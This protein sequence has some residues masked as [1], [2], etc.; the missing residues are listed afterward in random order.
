MNCYRC[1]VGAESR[2]C[3]AVAVCQRC[4]SGM[5]LQHLVTLSRPA[6]TGMNAAMTPGLICSH[7]FQ[8]LF[9]A[10]Q[11]RRHERTNKAG[12]WMERLSKR[13]KSR[14]RDEQVLPAPAEA[15]ELIERFLRQQKT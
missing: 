5:C 2:V 10:M 6:T 3:S 1:L 14:G 7:C 13:G 15:V 4:G 8:A 12:S 11:A 9:P